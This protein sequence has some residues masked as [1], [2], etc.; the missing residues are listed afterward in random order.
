VE[1]NPLARKRPVF[2]VL[3]VVFAAL[4]VLVPLGIVMSLPLDPVP[5]PDGG[6]EHDW[7]PVVRTLTNVAAALLSAVAAALLGLIAGLIAILRPERVRWLA[8]AG[9]V[10]NGLVLAFFA[11]VALRAWIS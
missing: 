8:V 6:P 10:A 1:P 11:L 4:T 7:E 9:L 3:S 5:R 2:G